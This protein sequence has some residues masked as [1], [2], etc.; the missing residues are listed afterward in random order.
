MASR[1]R[2][3][4]KDLP[5]LVSQRM[6]LR[7]LLLEEPELK[8]YTLSALA[9]NLV[10]CQVAI[11]GWALQG[12]H[13][14]LVMTQKIDGHDERRAVGIAPFMR[15]VTSTLAKKVNSTYSLQ[16]HSVERTYRSHNLEGPEN[17]LRSLAYI[18][19][20]DAHHHAT[21]PKGEP[22]WDSW[23]VLAG[24]QP[25]GVVSD[26]PE[27]WNLLAS[28]P[29]ERA[30]RARD[31]LRAII[32]CA[33]VLERDSQDNPWAVA[34]AEVVAL[35]KVPLTRNWQRLLPVPA[36]LDAAAHT[37]AH[38][39]RLAWQW[40]RI[41]FDPRRAPRVGDVIT[42]EVRREAIPPPFR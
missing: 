24:G 14:H 12:N 3:F 19:A 23:T 11:L 17:L 32:D 2:N 16:G 40:P 25:D 13:F 41:A 20:Q 37:K 31:L 34:T 21:R 38:E 10:R 36:A 4:R 27:F 28:S 22:R 33:L 29:E 1:K 30:E 5:V 8:E 9:R 35:H 39:A 26:L 18:H 7:L 42:I 6:V 15:N